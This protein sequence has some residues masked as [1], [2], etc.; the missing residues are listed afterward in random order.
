MEQGGGGLDAVFQ[1]GVDQALVEVQALLVD[2]AAA[3]GHHPAPGHAEA[4]GL[5]AQFLHQPDVLAPAVVMVAG[6]VAGVVVEHA[7]GGVGE[8]LPDAGTG[9]VGQR[10]A[11]DLVGRGGAT[12]DEVLGETIRLRHGPSGSV[13]KMW[14]RVG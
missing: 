12:P 6:H 1:Q 7:A 2:P 10:R 3:F 5:H 11:F 14:G 8:T 4:V 13:V 9:A